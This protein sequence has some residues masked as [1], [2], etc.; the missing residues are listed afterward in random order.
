MHTSSKINKVVNEQGPS[1]ILLI[2]LAQIL[3]LLTEIK[4][5]HPLIL[6]DAIIV[7]LLGGF[8]KLLESRQTF[9]GYAI[10]ECHFDEVDDYFLIQCFVGSFTVEQEAELE[11][12]C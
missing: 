7:L 8:Q 1:T 2:I 12:Q 3:T 9:R 4:K 6:R 10:F 11:T 5:R